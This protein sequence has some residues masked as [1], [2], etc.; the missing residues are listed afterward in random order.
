MNEKNRAVNKR[1]QTTWKSCNYKWRRT[2]N[3]SK[4][5]RGGALERDLYEIQSTLACEGDSYLMIGLNPNTSSHLTDGEIQVP[6]DE[7][8]PKTH[9]Y[10]GIVCCLVAQS[11]PTLCD[12]MDC[13][14]PGFPVL[15]YLSDFVQTHIHW[16][17]DVSQPSHPLWPTSPFAHSL[18]QHQG[19]FQRI[20]SSHQGGQSIKALASASVDFQWIFSVDFL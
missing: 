5:K 14:T 9:S 8:F 13:S 11:C 3:R 19:L 18:A 15:H 20:G 4:K 16:V 6:Q 2:K 10:L 1:S 7:L 17:N 12:S